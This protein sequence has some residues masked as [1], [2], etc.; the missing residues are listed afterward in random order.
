MFSA[1]LGRLRFR[2]P[3]CGLHRRSL[4]LGGSLGSD[5]IGSDRNV[6]RIASW[7]IWCGNYHVAG[8]SRAAKT[9]V[10]AYCMPATLCIFVSVSLLCQPIHLYL[11][12]SL[13]ASGRRG[14]GSVATV[15]VLHC[16]F[17]H[18]INASVSRQSV[19]NAFGSWCLGMLLVFCGKL[20]CCSWEALPKLRASFDPD[21]INFR[22]KLG[23]SSAL[24]MATRIFF[25]VHWRI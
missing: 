9:N 10:S 5:R 20:C 13:S 23:H 22:I 21:S 8:N 2:Q 18:I 12:L 4:I 19:F 16:Q 15:G 24:D 1:K 3:G 7:H 14:S 25:C 17:Y 11:H 6:C